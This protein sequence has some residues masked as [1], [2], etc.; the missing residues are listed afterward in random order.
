MLPVTPS[1]GHI[2]DADTRYQKLVRIAINVLR[3]VISLLL[4]K[5]KQVHIIMAEGNHDMSSSA[6]FREAFTALY[7]GEPRAT[8]DRSADIYYCYEFGETSLFFHHG[9]KIKASSNNADRAF[10]AK[11]RP[12]WGRTKY[13]YG[14]FGHLHHDMKNETELMTLE[15]HRTLAARNA[16]ESRGGWMSGRDAKVITYHKDYG[17]VSEVVISPEML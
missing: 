4:Q 5:H 12:I 3:R 7:E 8:V 13:S 2:M 1:S 6:W 14:H 17:R 11:F 15:Q 16:Y 9:H 10:A